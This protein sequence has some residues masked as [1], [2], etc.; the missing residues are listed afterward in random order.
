MLYT[1]L[2]IKDEIKSSVA[3]MGYTN[4]TEIQELAIPLILAGRDITA[5]APTGTGKTA[6]FGIPLVMLADTPHTSP[7]SVVLCPTREL[8]LQICEELEQLAKFFPHIKLVAVYGGEPIAK[9]IERLSDGAS[10]II[11]TPGRIKDHIEHKTID[12][13][14]VQTVVLDEADEMLNM[15]FYKDVMN[16][17]SKLPAKKHLHMFSATISR[18]VMDISWKHQNEPAEITV[19]PT[20]ESRPQISQYSILTTGRNKIADLTGLILQ[21]GYKKLIVFC[22]TK[23]TTQAVCDK[24]ESQN[25]K[26]VPL[27]GDM[28]QAERNKIMAGFR[29]GDADILV[30]TDVAARGIDVSDIEAV[31]NFDIPQTNEYYLHRIGRTG[32][33]KK[34]GVSYLLYT[35]EDKIR[36][37]EIVK[38]TQ[39]EV[40]EIRCGFGVY[41]ISPT[42][43]WQ[44]KE[45][46]TLFSN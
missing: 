2:N 19:E 27:S 31:F 30:A 22:N 26:A 29:N 39:S 46:V 12:L 10:I 43:P 37:S 20:Q 40:I 34:E 38:Q 45:F 41:E 14:A 3:E 11:A 36:I 8:C 5:K 16:I 6:A 4:L 33:A 15:G 32:R 25:F 9:Q 18:E 1:E 21:C 7:L 35:T 24:L 42:N 28:S 17:I 13:S 44:K 23:Y